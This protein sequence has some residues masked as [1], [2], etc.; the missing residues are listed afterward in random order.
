[1]IVGVDLIDSETKGILVLEVN[2]WPDMYDIQEST[3]LPVFRTLVTTFYDRVHHKATHTHQLSPKI[4]PN[5]VNNTIT[6]DV[7]LLTQK[8]QIID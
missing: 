6:H 8:Q 7:S 4:L 3:Q 5:W 2:M 1:M